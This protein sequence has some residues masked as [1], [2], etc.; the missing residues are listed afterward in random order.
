MIPS[1]LVRIRPVTPWRIGADSG[2]ASQVSPVLHSDALYS[3]L[4]LAFGQLGQMEDWLEATARPHGEPAVRLSSCFPWQRGFLYAPPPAGLWPPAETAGSSAARTRLKGAK[5]VPTS[6]IA[7]LA[8]GQA[9][10]GS[11]WAVDAQSACLIPAQSRSATG[12][13]RVVWRSSAAVDR[14][15]GGNAIAHTAGALQFAP[16]SGLWCAAAFSSQTAYAVWA[17]KLE[18]AFRL[19][20]DSGVGGLRS[21][22]FGR[23]RTPDFEAGLLD[24]MLFGAGAATAAGANGAW[25]LL[26]VYSPDP[27]DTVDWGAGDY[28]LLVRTGRVASAAAGGG[29]KRASR[30]VEEGSVLVAPTA[31]RGMVRNVAPESSPHPVWRSGYA[32]ALRIPWR[33]AA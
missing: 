13:F 9:F 27:S 16:A 21:R 33:G 18:A 3:A 26:S 28:R 30:V 8:S 6:V 1:L 22:G 23:A 11:A 12:P 20:A 2:D 17:P 10:D 19:L 15:T 31:P 24:E 29:E 4:T 32:L 25:W 7:A 5:L 14:V